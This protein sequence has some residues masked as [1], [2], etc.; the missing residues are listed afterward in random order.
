[1]LSE[2]LVVTTEVQ[3]LVHP[4]AAGGAELAAPTAHQEQVADGVFSPEAQHA[5]AW[6]LQLQ[7]GLGLLQHIRAEAAPA[8]EEPQPRKARPADLDPAG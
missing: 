3:P 8:E 2:P 6:M 1:M 5:A 4:P 7:A